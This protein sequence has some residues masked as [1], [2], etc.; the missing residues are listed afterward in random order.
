M[1]SLFEAATPSVVVTAVVLLREIRS[2]GDAR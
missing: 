2:V 1:A